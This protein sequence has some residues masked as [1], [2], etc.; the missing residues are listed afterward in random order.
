MLLVMRLLF[1]IKKAKTQASTTVFKLMKCN[2]KT[3]AAAI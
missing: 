1:C 2:W 3:G